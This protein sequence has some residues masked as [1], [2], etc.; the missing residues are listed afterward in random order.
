MTVGKQFEKNFAMICFL[1][2]PSGGKRKTHFSLQ[3]SE[4]PFCLPTVTHSPPV[5]AIM[6]LNIMYRQKK[7]DGNRPRLPSVSVAFLCILHNPLFMIRVVGLC[8]MLKLTI[9]Q[10]KSQNIIDIYKKGNNNA[11]RVCIERA[12]MGFLW[13]R[14]FIF[15]TGCYSRFK[16]IISHG[17]GSLNVFSL[18]HAFW[19]IRKGN[20]KPTF[21]SFVN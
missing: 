2:S 13:Q 19:K 8:N 4:R 15:Q 14:F 20:P 11:K 3:N 12:D 9:F 16:G 17:I 21:F 7:T 10:R 18:R 1:L 6:A 5:S